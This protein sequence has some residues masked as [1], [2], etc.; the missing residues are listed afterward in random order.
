MVTIST[1]YQH[2]Y[3]Q[4]QAIIQTAQRAGY[5]MKYLLLEGG[6]LIDNKVS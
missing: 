4:L 6:T 2:Y 5:P 3:L 1:E